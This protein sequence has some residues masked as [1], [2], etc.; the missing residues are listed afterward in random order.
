MTEFFIF[1]IIELWINDLLSTFSIDY[2][3]ILRIEPYNVILHYFLQFFYQTHYQI[4]LLFSLIHFYL[5]TSLKIK[6]HCKHILQMTFLYK[7]KWDWKI[8]KE[9]FQSKYLFFIFDSFNHYWYLSLKK[10]ELTAT[11]TW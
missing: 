10:I 9:H 5:L 2:K 6:I 1:N 11:N 3:S 4:L 8:F 7:A